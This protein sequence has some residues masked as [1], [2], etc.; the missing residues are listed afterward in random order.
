MVHIPWKKGIITLICKILSQEILPYV[1]GAVS[2]S[3]VHL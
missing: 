2:R 3:E 1:Q